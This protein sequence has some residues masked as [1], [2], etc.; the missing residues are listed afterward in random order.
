[1]ETM[2]SETV[3]TETIREVTAPQARET[4]QKS[5]F[6]QKLVIVSHVTH[7]HANGRIYA[8]A[9]YAREIEIWAELF[10]EIVIAAPSR[11]AEPPGDCALIDRANVRVAPQR[12]LGGET[13]TAKLKLVLAT[14]VMAWELCKV[15]RRADAIHVR[16]PGN[17]GLLGTVFAPLFSKKL[18]AKFAG[19]WS[20][21]QNEPW[22]T[23]FQRSVLNS[24]WWHG[25]VTVYGRWPN[26]PAHVIPFFSAALT[27]EQLARARPAIACR[28]LQNL[29]HVLFVGRLSRAKNVD[30]L[31]QAL[32]QLRR[33][34]ASFTVTIAGEGPQLA[35]LQK[36]S[37]DLGI[38]DRVEFT[39][40]V[41]FERIIEL[42]ESS[43]IL[44]LA[45]ETEGWPKAI[46]EAMAFGLVT[47][48]S[49]IGL[50]P[51]IMA[52]G[53]GLMVTPRNVEELSAALRKVLAAPE[54][55]SE[56]RA[57]A[58]EWAGHYSIESLRE[59]LRSLLAESW[60]LQ[61]GVEPKAQRK[62]TAVLG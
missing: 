60:S 47:I 21:G 37:A 54:Q 35:S 34:G 33:E 31:L 46:V 41:S 2:R 3:S 51:E 27:D 48:G 18:V 45:S 50:V 6:H 40:G 23:R 53:R 4:A 16:C 14:P 32:G 43:G 15:M 9:P 22:S 38:A 25:P 62:P 26:Q 10:D 42:L 44:V 30:V 61:A 11:N 59:S 57:R 12:E 8:Y 24:R 28:T 39:G 19:Q 36:L 49:Q 56:M 29:R 7:F 1:M 20:R 58:A 17:I 55:Y 5:R 13:L 52:Q